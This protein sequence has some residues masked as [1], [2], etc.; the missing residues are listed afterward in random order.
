[1]DQ[2]GAREIKGFTS[3]LP[4]ALSNPPTNATSTEERRRGE[5]GK[6]PPPATDTSLRPLLLDCE[7]AI[8]LQ[9]P[10]TNWRRQTRRR[11]AVAEDQDTDLI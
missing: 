5:R 2:N 11:I 4:T 1:M 9:A 10:A 6:R 7:P 3:P 8:E